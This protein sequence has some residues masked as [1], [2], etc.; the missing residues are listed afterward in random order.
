DFVRRALFEEPP[1]TG[2]Q[3]F[4]ILAHHNEVDVCRSLALQ[5]RVDAGIEFHWTQIDVLVEIEAQPQQNALL[6]NAGAHVWMADGAEENGL[7]LSHL[8]HRA[9]RQHLTGT[10]IALAA[11]VVASGFVLEP[12]AL[13][14][15]A[16]HLERFCNDLGTG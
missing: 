9:I 8:V 12:E 3:A 4:G 14:G 5:R 1:A 6:E 2:V 13:R 15:A 16:E 11:K 10:L 7:E